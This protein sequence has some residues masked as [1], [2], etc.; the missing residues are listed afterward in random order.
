MGRKRKP[1][2][3]GRI[4]ALKP[5]EIEK[6]RSTELRKVTTILNSAANKRIKRA[7]ALGTESKVIEKALEGGRFQTSRVSKKTPEAEARSIAYAEFMR[8][9]TF[10]SKQTSSTR[11]VKKQ[12]TKVLKQFIKKAKKI[13]NVTGTDVGSETGQVSLWWDSL[14]G[15]DKEKLN[16]LVWTQVDKLA[17]EKPLTKEQRYRASAAAY[18]AATQMDIR[19]KDAMFKYL[20]EWRD[21]EYEDLVDDNNDI[22]DDEIAEA[23]RDYDI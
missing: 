12:Q 2:T 16:D 14:T 9:R 21:K 11:G 8:V 4:L 18:E 7:Y 22:G 17:E 23:F 10:L 1:L 15:E 20:E 19:D 5:K 3:V 6:M 13:T